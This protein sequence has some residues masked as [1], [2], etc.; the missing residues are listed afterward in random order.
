MSMTNRTISQVAFFYDL[1]I[2]TDGSH[3]GLEVAA[4]TEGQDTTE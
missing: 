4:T 2:L 1:E 3:N